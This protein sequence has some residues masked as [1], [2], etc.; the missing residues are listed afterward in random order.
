MRAVAL[1]GD[2]VLGFCA[3]GGGFAPALR[4]D[5]E[6]SRRPGR[7]LDGALG[8]RRPISVATQLPP[9]P[10][11]GRGENLTSAELNSCSGSGCCNNVVCVPQNSRDTSRILSADP[12]LSPNCGTCIE[13]SNALAASA[14]RHLV[15]L[16]AS[17]GTHNRLVL[18]PASRLGQ[19]GARGMRSSER[20]DRKVRVAM[21][22]C[23]S[24]QSLSAGFG[25]DI[26]F[27]HALRFATYIARARIRARR[28]SLARGARAFA[29]SVRSSTRGTR[30]GGYGNMKC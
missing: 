8:V 17:T 13:R 29:R 19:C 18:T 2:T 6:V 10:L 3:P 7:G 9:D 4:G 14:L 24:S 28:C 22:R 5:I 12:R 30:V 23:R 20:C 25:F 1:R 15:L 21:S 11:I 16:W 26:P 27:V